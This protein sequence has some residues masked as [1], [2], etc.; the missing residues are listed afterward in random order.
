MALVAGAAAAQAPALHYTVHAG[1][2]A[3]VDGTIPLEVTLRIAAPPA[4]HTVFA[5]PVW[6]PG[7]YRLRDFPER[8]TMLAA[9]TDAGPV[10]V[11]TL[12]R[13]SWLVQHGR[14]AAVEVRYRVALRPGDRFMDPGDGRR[15]ITYEGPAVYLYAEGLLAAPCRVRFDLPEGWAVA[16]GLARADDG[17]HAAADYDVLADCPVKLG[18]FQTFGFQSQGTGFEAVVD[19]ETDLD[20]DVAGWLAGLQAIVDEA[21]AVFGGGFPCARYAFLFT[22]TSRGGGGGL[23]HLNSTAIGLSRARFV[24]DP[25]SSYGVCAH[26]FFHC[27]NVKRLRPVE[28]GPFRYDRPVRTT[29]LWLSEGVTSYYAAVL[30]A[31]AGHQTAER[32]WTGMASGVA[33]WEGMRGRRFTSPEQ[34]SLRV[35]D[36][37]P[38]DRIVDYYTAGLVL[39]LLLDLEIRH[40]SGNARSLDDAMAAMWQACERQRR[41]LH[42][43]EIES[44]CSATAGVDLGPFFAAHVRGTVVPDYATLLSHAGMQ[45][46]LGST[47]TPV[48]RGADLGDRDRPSF[49]DFASLERSG[50]GDPSS[51]VGRIRAIDEAAVATSEDVERLLAAAVAR[52]KLRLRVDYENANGLHRTADATIEQALRTRCRIPPAD[53]ASATQVALR[54]GITARRRP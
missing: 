42:A 4:E 22:V 10:P 20:F 45:V 13:T 7:S 14:T 34:A 8:I 9:A 30:L 23:E 11:T 48:L 29:G 16:S 47:A 35:W 18:R 5:I 26:E 17:T 53:D 43:E 27:W 19:A 12:S 37:Q 49:R 38:P 50:G 6:T 2:G 21:A 36:P 1:S 24:R 46:D 31:R 41:G 25:A 52:G 51:L 44:I 15:C 33:R 28:L 32:F 54:A 3:T 39:G 40:A